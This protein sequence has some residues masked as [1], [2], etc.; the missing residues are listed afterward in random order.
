L[1]R[2][3]EK[4][5]YTEASL[6]IGCHGHSTASKQLFYRVAYAQP[7]GLPRTFL[8]GPSRD[9]LPAGAVALVKPRSASVCWR[10]TAGEP[11]SSPPLTRLGRSAPL[12]P[13]DQAL[14]ICGY[15]G[16][17]GL[18]GQLDESGGGAELDLNPVDPHDVVGRSISLTRIASRL[19]VLARIESIDVATFRKILRVA[20]GCQPEP[21]FVD[22]PSCQNES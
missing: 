1:E 5:L 18:E 6:G 19:F 3:L 4:A 21:P 10:Q 7:G 8:S 20:P 9:R 17:G 12:L 14:G 2:P 16:L 22:R 13:I 11:E 15:R